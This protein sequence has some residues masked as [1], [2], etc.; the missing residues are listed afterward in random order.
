MIPT[1]IVVGLLLG[2]RWR[3]ALVAAAVGW[4]ALLL[5][6]GT[7]DAGGILPAAV[8]G[9]VNAAVGVAV[10]Q[11]G[12]WGLRHLRRPAARSAEAGQGR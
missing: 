6:T 10:V 9:V 11:G 5:A 2:Y 3:T 7:I 12:L 1:M 4:P 8:L